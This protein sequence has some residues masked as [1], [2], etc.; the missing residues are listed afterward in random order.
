LNTD[1]F[2]PSSS[3]QDAQVG[4]LH[5]VTLITADKI[6]VQRMF[7]EG[8]DL[9]MTPWVSPTKEESL[10]LN[11]YFGF[12]EHKLIEYCCFFRAGEYRNIQV[13]VLL[14]SED[15]PMVR[16]EVDGR[17]LGGTTIGFPMSEFVDREQKMAGLGMRSTVGEK[18]LEFTGAG[19]ETYVSSEIHFV[20]VENVFMLGVKRPESFVQVGPIDPDTDIGAAAYS[21]RCVQNLDSVKDFFSEVLGYEIRRDLAMEIGPKSGLRMQE[22]IPERFVQ[23][24]APG[25][26]TGYAVFLEHG[27]Q[28]IQNIDSSVAP[29]N[30]GLVMWSFGTKDLESLF[31]KAQRAGVDFIQEPEQRV[32]PGL[33]STSTMLMVDPDGFQIEVFETW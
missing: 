18:R 15:I 19:G 5:T 26:A 22:G 27:G 8:L 20:G 24:F 31:Q 32:I 14:V 25:A 33:G 1:I 3:P 30:R 9:E 28:G 29:P 11:P 12:D 10:M 16:P 17:Y 2:V 6:G 21:A 4:P 7:T 13:R 23:A